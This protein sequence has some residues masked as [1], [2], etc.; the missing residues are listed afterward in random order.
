MK[1]E[2]LELVVL[3]LVMTLRDIYDFGI[4]FTDSDDVISD[5]LIKVGSA[6]ALK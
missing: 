6:F 5:W 4:W 3:D 1:A 2:R